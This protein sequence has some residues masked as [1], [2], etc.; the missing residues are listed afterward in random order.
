MLRPPQPIA[1]N[2]YDTPRNAHNQVPII[3]GRNDM[4]AAFQSFIDGVTR[5]IEAYQQQV[6]ENT[7]TAASKKPSPVKISPSNPKP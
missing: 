6:E 2:P 4:Y 5:S 3:N 1:V 7:A